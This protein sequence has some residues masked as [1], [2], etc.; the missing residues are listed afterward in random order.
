MSIE[1]LQGYIWCNPFRY[2]NW[3]FSKLNY[4][5][6]LGLIRHAH[7]DEGADAFVPVL[8]YVVLKT[9]PEHLISNVEYVRFSSWHVFFSQT[10]FIF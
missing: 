7:M 9:N 5:N 6:I 4:I 3:N 2:L 8:I 1:L 10:R